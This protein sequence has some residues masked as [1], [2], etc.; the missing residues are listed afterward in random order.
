MIQRS[1]NE[2]VGA[3]SGNFLSRGSPNAG[4]SQST[5]VSGFNLNSSLNNLGT[6]GLGASFGG[7][8]GRNNSFGGFNRNM[9]NQGTQNSANQLR[10]RIN[11]GFTVPM[12]TTTEVSARFTDR[13]PKLPGLASVSGL[14]VQMDGQTAV[15][16]G[17]V[18]SE[19]QRDLISRLAKLEPGIG[20]VRNELTVA[21]PSPSDMV[22]PRASAEEVPANT[23]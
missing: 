11:L 12:P 19:S 21:A 16:Q 3:S 1:A 23:P 15:L 22:P 4:Q 14:T 10:F 5:G 9:M 6:L 18:A 13:L 20:E 17:V 8:F 7:A 2:F